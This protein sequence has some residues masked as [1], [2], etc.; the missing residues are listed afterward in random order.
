MSTLIGWLAAVGAAATIAPSTPTLP[1]SAGRSGASQASPIGRR[2]PAPTAFG[3]RGPR[4]M[5]WVPSAGGKQWTNEVVGGQEGS[6]RLVICRADH[7]GGKHPGKRVAGKC[8]FGYGGREIEALKY[9]VLVAGSISP[10]W[11]DTSSQMPAAGAFVSGQYDG[12]PGHVCRAM[13]QGNLHPGKVVAG[14]CNI[15][16]GGKEVIL[17]AYQTLLDPNYTPPAPPMVAKPAVA[18]Q[19][20]V[21]PVLNV[22]PPTQ[23]P[24]ERCKNELQNRVAWDDK[25]S[26]RWAE[27]NLEALC[28]NGQGVQPARCFERVMH[29]NVSWGGGTKWQWKN[30]LELCG[31]AQNAERTVGCFQRKISKGRPW[32]TAIAKCKG[33]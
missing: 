28:R 19:P 11:S 12:R 20:Q 10:Q 13:Y 29:G 16:Y 25:G 1:S 31:G 8:N 33:R 5:T 22:Q 21:P 6:R 30:A 32:Q 4:G 14:N 15:G 18:I 9:D 23:S 17:R 3:Q 27:A 2:A 7:A 26:K 24:L